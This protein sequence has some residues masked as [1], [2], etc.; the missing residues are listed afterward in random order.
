MKENY[1]SIHKNPTQHSL[2]V[3]ASLC[4]LLSWAI[5]LLFTSS[6]N[7]FF[8]ISYRQ[9]VLMS[10]YYTSFNLFA[11]HS[12][13]LTRALMCSHRV[14]LITSFLLLMIVWMNVMVRVKNMK[15]IITIFK[16]EI[17]SVLY[18]NFFKIFNFFR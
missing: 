18:V 13:S 11:F 6:P 7:V 14:F 17:E 3:S 9:R 2:Y 1:L 8:F 5:N 15:I 12:L 16:T 4:L 10:R